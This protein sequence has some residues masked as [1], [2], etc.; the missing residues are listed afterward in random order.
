VAERFAARPDRVA[1]WAFLLG[2]FL[3]VVAAISAH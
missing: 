3:I 2:L 1:Q